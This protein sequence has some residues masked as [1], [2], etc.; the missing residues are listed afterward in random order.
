[1][2]YD[3]K[4]K[5]NVLFYLRGAATSPDPASLFRVDLF[6]RSSKSDA[7]VHAVS[8]PPHTRADAGVASVAGIFATFASWEA[9]IYSAGH[10][11]I[12]DKILVIDPFTDDSVVVTGSHNLGFR[13]SYN[14]DENM[15]VI[16]G[17]RGVAQAYAAHVLDVY[18]H[19]RWRWKIQQPVRDKFAEL[20]AKNPNAK[21]AELWK[22]TMAAVGESTIDKVWKNLEPTDHWQD[23]YVKNK[24]LLAAEVNFWSSFEGVGLVRR[25]APRRRKGGR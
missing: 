19:Y 5:A 25:V 15:L 17:N 10:A 13:A 4:T 23:Y 9:E 21:A 12:H 16:R 14:N 6:H 20:K 3:A 1:E 24:D 8:N 2:V 11:V 18:E 22:K 7:A